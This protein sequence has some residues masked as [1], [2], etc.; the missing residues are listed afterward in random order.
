MKIPVSRTGSF[1][2]KWLSN[3][4]EPESQQVVCEYNYIPWETRRKYIAKDKTKLII[5]DVET[6]SD[7][8]L[9]TAV[10]AQHSKFEMTFSTDDEG[11]TAAMKPRFKNLED[12]QG[13]VIDTWD[14]LL[15]TP[16]SPENKIDE[17][18]TEVIRHCSRQAKEQDI[19]NS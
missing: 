7:T 16:A 12:D 17:L 2:P 3:Q 14:K 1:I 10:M 4:D 9:D 6:Q 5:D 13:N 18:V 19:K 15:K 11:I 8:E